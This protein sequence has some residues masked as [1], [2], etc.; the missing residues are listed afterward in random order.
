[1]TDGEE[2]ELLASWP[3]LLWGDAGADDDAHGRLPP[4]PSPEL[5]RRAVPDQPAVPQ[6][7]PKRPA[8]RP[9]KLAPDAA[10]IGASLTMFTGP[11]GP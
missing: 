9:A 8:E 11:G 5:W 4:A 1:M 10:G 6:V 3:L 2:Q 7:L